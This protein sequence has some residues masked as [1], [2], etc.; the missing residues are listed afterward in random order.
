MPSSPQ[1]KEGEYCFACQSAGLYVSWFPSPCA[2]SG[3]L[4]D[5]A[6]SKVRGQVYFD[7]LGKG[8]ISDLQKSFILL[9]FDML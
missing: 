6:I 2:A 7:A 8:I 9:A 3:Q 4:I 5:I 1:T